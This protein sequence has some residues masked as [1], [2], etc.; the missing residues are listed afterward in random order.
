MYL[1]TPVCVCF[2]ILFP[3]L[4][5][6]NLQIQNFYFSFDMFL[7]NFFSLS[8]VAVLH[9]EILPFDREET[10]ELNVIFLKVDRFLT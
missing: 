2:V 3:K 10:R 4:F 6:I 5:V 7:R 8:C 1:K 9:D